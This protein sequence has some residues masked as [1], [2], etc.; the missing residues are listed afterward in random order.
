M[1]FM[2]GIRIPVGTIAIPA[3]PRILSISTRRT[4]DAAVR[5]L[6]PLID[7]VPPV[8]GKRG[9]PR[10]QPG[11]LSLGVYRW[12]VEQIFALLHWFRRLRMS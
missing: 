4:V 6:M 8:R 9:R 2:R 7:M 1:E 12:V 10:F 5:W 11:C 3:M